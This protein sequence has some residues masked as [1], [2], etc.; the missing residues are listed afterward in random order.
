MKTA[1]AVVEQ[2]QTPAEI[3]V[4]S[5]KTMGFNPHGSAVVAVQRVQEIFEDAKDELASMNRIIT[6]LGCTA[7]LHTVQARILAKTLTQEFVLR[8]GLYEA[9]EAMKVAAAKYIDMEKTMPFLFIASEGGVTP[10]TKTA[11]GG[12]TRV[13]KVQ[14]AKRGGDK[15]E[16]ALVIFNTYAG[17][18]TADSDIAKDIAKQLEITFANAYYYVTRVFKKKYGASTGSKKKGRK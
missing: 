17:K 10:I 6:T 14:K 7:V 9:E 13:A 16:R 11:V 18:E 12:G 5:M 4:L 1:V 15:K 2:T 8:G 3:M